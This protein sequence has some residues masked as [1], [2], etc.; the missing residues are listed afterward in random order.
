MTMNLNNSCLKCTAKLANQA[1]PKKDKIQK[2]LDFTCQICQ[3][4]YQLLEIHH[5]K[6]NRCEI[7]L[8]KWKSLLHQHFQEQ[9]IL[10]LAQQEAHKDKD[11]DSK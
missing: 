3:S 10:H 4:F 9:I 2:Q 1:Q 6:S 8:A 11:H 5:I 7:C